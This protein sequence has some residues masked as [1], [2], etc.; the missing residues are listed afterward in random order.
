MGRGQQVQRYTDL[1]AEPGVQGRVFQCGQTRHVGC[2]L[3]KAGLVMH[4]AGPILSGSDDASEA[5]IQSELEVMLQ[6][7][8][9]LGEMGQTALSHGRQ[10]GLP[11]QIP[12]RTVTLFLERT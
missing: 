3:H 4:P 6:D 11:D 8:T 5:E 7:R 10:R 2:C 1:I 12:G 9:R